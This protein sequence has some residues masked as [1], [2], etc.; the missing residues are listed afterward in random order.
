MLAQSIK[1]TLKIAKETY[2]KELGKGNK[3]IAFRIKSEIN[4]LEIQLKILENKL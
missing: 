3:K 2:K 1:T 4:N